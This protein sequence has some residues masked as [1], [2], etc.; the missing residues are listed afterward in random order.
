MSGWK[1][2]LPMYGITPRLREANNALLDALATTLK[3]LGWSEPIRLVEADFAHIDE[4]WLDPQLLLSQTCGYPLMTRLQGKVSLLALPHYRAEGF[5]D[6][7]YRSRLIVAEQSRFTALAELRGAVA[8]ING[9]DSHS[10]MNALR[11]AVAPLADNG[12]FF[13]EVRVSGGH[14]NSIQYVHN[15]QAD[16]AA[17]DPVTWAHLL[18]EQPERLTRIRTLGWSAPAP[19]LPLIGSRALTDEQ[20]SLIRAALAATL[21]NAPHLARVLRIEGFGEAQWPRYQRIIDMQRQVT[22]LPD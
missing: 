10:G 4:H 8:V 21:H 3:G 7:Q 18:D 2:S 17:I 6:G 11:H 9:A 12:D 14:V 13:R 22:G 16:V 15:G 19:G 1:V 5:K 20:T